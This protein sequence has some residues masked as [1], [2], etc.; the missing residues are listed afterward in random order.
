MCGNSVFRNFVHFHCTNLNFKRVP[1]WTNHRCMKRLIHVRLWHRNIILKSAWHRLP[2]CMNNTKYRIAVFNAVN[3]NTYSQQII[4]FIKLLILHDHF[5]INTI[6][7]FRSAGEFSLNVHLRHAVFYF[8]NNL[9]QVFLTFRSF[10]LHE[11]HNPVVLL[12]I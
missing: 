12:R 11:I 2:A 5:S 7:M 1:F 10:A 3:Q 8:I 4:Y 9:V 6:N